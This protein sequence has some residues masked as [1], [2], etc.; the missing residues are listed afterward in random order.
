MI[1]SVPPLEHGETAYWPLNYFTQFETDKELEVRITLSTKCLHHVR[2]NTQKIRV[3]ILLSIEKIE[4][5]WPF[6]WGY[7]PC[8]ECMFFS[9]NARNLIFVCFEIKVLLIN[10]K[11]VKTLG[12]WLKSINEKKF[13]F[14]AAYFCYTQFPFSKN[15]YIQC[16]T[17]IWNGNKVNNN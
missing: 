11:L 4:K 2:C 12:T 13:L 9:K 10:L 16:W 8:I 1:F 14:L 3:L 15:T 6:D 5:V 17:S 7:A